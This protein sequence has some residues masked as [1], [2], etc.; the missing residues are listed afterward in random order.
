[1]VKFLRVRVKVGETVR[2]ETGTGRA[3][4]AMPPLSS[5]GVA[6]RRLPPAP[7]QARAPGS[8][9]AR[10]AAAATSAL[11][12]LLRRA[13]RRRADFRRSRRSASIYPP[14]TQ[15]IFFARQITMLGR[16]LLLFRAHPELILSPDEHFTL[17]LLL[18]ARNISFLHDVP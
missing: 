3:T 2:A 12:E 1:M 18:R 6:P 8:P 14:R 11:S 9:G 10:Q 15:I 16:T 7:Q 5:S 17:T 4:C 13:R